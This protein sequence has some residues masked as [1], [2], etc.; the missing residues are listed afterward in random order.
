MD[1][2][3]NTLFINA[4]NLILIA[5]ESLV[6]ITAGI[7]LYKNHLTEGTR[8]ILKSALEIGIGWVL[9]RSFWLAA[10]MTAPIH[11]HY[12]PW[13]LENK[14]LT[15]IPVLVVAHGT[16]RLIGTLYSLNQKK[17]IFFLAIGVM[18]SG[19]LGI[20]IGSI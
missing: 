6:V 7:S 11:M 1:I 10:T 8:C 15:I 13:F 3:I 4:G 12:N 19:G 18:A 17:C 20:A 14:W 16:S 2:E 5:A 9:H